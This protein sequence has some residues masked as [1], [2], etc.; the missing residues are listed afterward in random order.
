MLV[1][2]GYLVLEARHGEDALEVIAQEGAVDLLVT[3]VVMP[4]MGGR[5]LATQIRTQFPGTPVL[6]MT[7]YTE[8]ELLRRGAMETG[9]TVLRKPFTSAELVKSVE[10]LLQ[11]CCLT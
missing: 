6:F 3:D 11:G 8:D 9:A 7:G 2:A 10:D 1:G 5:E 4:Q